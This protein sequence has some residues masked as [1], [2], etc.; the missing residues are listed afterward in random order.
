MTPGPFPV[1]KLPRCGVDHPLTPR[2][3]VKERVELCLY[4]PSVPSWSVLGWT[5]PFLIFK[6]SL[7][8]SAFTGLAVVSD[9]KSNNH[10][11][12]LQPK[13]WNVSWFIYFYRRSTFSRLSLP[14]SSGAHK[15]T[16]IFRYCQPTLLLAAI[17]DE[18]ELRST[19]STIAA[20][21]SIGWQYPKLYVQLCV[22]DDGR[23]NRL[24]H[25][26]RL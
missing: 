6:L 25:V 20:S 11:S 21:S 5:L 19:S 24:K 22:P 17:V 2:T 13:R 18:M 3:E 23:R 7:E 14:P 10:V 26:E 1:V 9:K 15:C 16:Y 8:H 4:F 12:K